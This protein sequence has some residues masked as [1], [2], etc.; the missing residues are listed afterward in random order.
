MLKG[1]TTSLE[2]CI[3]WNYTSKV[4]KKKKMTFRKWREFVAS[5]HAF[6][7]MLKEVLQTQRKWHRSETQIE[8]KKERTL[9]KEQMK[10]KML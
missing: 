2:F 10:V 8:V 6:Q 7:K 3:K 4:R 9:E 1:K 5:K